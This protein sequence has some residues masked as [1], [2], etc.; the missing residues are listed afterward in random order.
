MRY[1]QTRQ[2]N[3]NNEGYIYVNSHQDFNAPVISHLSSAPILLSLRS[4]RSCWLRGQSSRVSQ[5]LDFLLVVVS[6][7]LALPY[8]RLA[9]LSCSL[10]LF[11][12]LSLPRYDVTSQ[13]PPSLSLSLSRP[14]RHSNGD[15]AWKETT[16]QRKHTHTGH[17]LPLLPLSHTH[18]SMWNK[19]IVRSR[20]TFPAPSRG[21]L[22][23]SHTG[24]W[25]D[26]CLFS[27][28]R[29]FRTLEFILKLQMQNLRTSTFKCCNQSNNSTM[30]PMTLE[31]TL[32]PQNQS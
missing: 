22:F 20:E 26:V 27:E 6:C 25:C 21:L 31:P 32:E 16:K 11:L 5:V 24:C 4:G 23:L 10:T 9:L 29:R 17:S 15:S 1:S 14:F 8:A 18:T 2:Y 7:S 28:L 12:S 19:V 3:N 13:P 30:N